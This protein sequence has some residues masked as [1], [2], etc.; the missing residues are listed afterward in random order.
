MALGSTRELL[1]LPKIWF[2]DGLT[3]QSPTL[4]SPA[5]LFHPANIIVS[6]RAAGAGITSTT[7]M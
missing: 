5:K 7:N 6:G 3:S 4:K 1:P 2:S